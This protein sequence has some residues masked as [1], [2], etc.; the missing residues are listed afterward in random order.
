ML[1]VVVCMFGVCSVG[2][3]GSGGGC[4]YSYNGSLYFSVSNSSCSG[5]K[6][7]LFFIM[8][9]FSGSVFFMKLYSSL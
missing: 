5:K 7:N 4:E 8:C 6:G 9:M 1:S 2:A 3:L